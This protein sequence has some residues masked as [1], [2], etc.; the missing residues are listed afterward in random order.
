[1]PQYIALLR[2]I[3]VG[4][5]N[6]VAMPRLRLG[7]EE[8]GF[9]AVSTYINS[10]NVI[11]TSPNTNIEELAAQCRQLIEQHFALQIPVAVVPA[12]QITNALKN[13]PA[14]WGA[15]EESK[16]NAIFV[17]PPATAQQIAQLVGEAKP[18]YEQVD[19]Y[20]NVIFWSAPLKTFSRTRWSKIV[21]SK[22]AYNAITIRNYNTT[23]KLAQLVTNK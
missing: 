4:G 16:H 9:T 10:G 5:N 1:M 2:G 22:Q 23:Q 6:T 3:N 12:A 19:F 20:E 17:I 8:A 18:E 11:F 14:W 13:A 7:F 15:S 21:Q